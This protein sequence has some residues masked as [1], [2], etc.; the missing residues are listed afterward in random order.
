MV[1][2]LATLSRAMPAAALASTAR[3]PVTAMPRD[4]QLVRLLANILL[5]T[6]AELT[7]VY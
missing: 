6:Q 7:H 3:T 1:A 2:G 4:P 5:R